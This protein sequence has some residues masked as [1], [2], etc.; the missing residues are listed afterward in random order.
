MHKIAAPANNIKAGTMELRHAGVS[1]LPTAVAQEI[2][3]FANMPV[4]DILAYLQEQ[5]ELTR[6]TIVHILTESGRLEDFSL[7]RTATW[8]QLLGS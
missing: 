7:T 8:T 6:S 1:A 5:T 4:P 3:S 2:V